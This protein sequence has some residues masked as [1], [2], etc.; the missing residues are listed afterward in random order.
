[1]LLEI[2][3]RVYSRNQVVVLSRLFTWCFCQLHNFGIFEE[4]HFLNLS[5][6]LKS[7]KLRKMRYGNP[8][9]NIHRIKSGWSLLKGMPKYLRPEII[10]RGAHLVHAL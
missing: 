6:L 9:Q 4:G 1:M 3:D 8:F 2:F 7:E 5:H 10:L